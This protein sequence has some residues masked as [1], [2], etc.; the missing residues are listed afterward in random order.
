MNIIIADIVTESQYCFDVKTQ[1]VGYGHENSWNI[2]CADQYCQMCA[3]D[4]TFSS[5]GQHHQKCCLPADQNEYSIN[6]FDSSEDGWHGGYLEIN[7]IKYCEDFLD[8]SMTNATMQNS[9]IGIERLLQTKRV[10]R[11][12]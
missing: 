5:R 1:T 10:V 7:G 9:N 4:V 2:G 8:G 6:C 3:N 11:L 12:I